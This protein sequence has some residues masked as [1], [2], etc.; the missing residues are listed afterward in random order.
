MVDHDHFMALAIAE[1]RKG[2]AMGEQPFGALIALNGEVIVK[3][4]SLKV[5]SSDTTRH[6]ETYR[7]RPRNPKAQAAH[8]A[9][10]RRFFMQPASLAQCAREPS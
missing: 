3:T 6:S 9:T 5:S 10:R 4:P 1:A 7:D 8:V 2:A